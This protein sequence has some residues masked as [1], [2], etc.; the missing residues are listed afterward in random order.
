MSNKISCM[1]CLTPGGAELRLDKRGRPYTVCPHCL[2]RTFIHS[3]RGLRGI[4]VWNSRT[5]TMLQQL[6][7]A[8]FDSMDAASEEQ[9]TAWQQQ[10]RMG[11][12]VNG[13][14]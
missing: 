8:G 1:N 12:A 13:G 10:R 7:Q 2:S 14:E 11:A 4:R 5:L 6:A 3:P 9:W